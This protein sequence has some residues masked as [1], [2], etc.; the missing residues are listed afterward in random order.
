MT[1]ELNAK[2]LMTHPVTVLREVETVER[3]LHIL[4]STKHNGFPVVE[5]FD[6]ENSETFGILK[7]FI[8]RHQLFTLLKHKSFLLTNRQLTPDDFREYYPTYL[9]FKDIEI[10]ENEFNLELDLRPYMNLAPYSLSENSNLP[11][12]F[13]LFRG[14]GLRHIV[15]V[16]KKNNVVGIVTRIDVAKYRAHFGF[17]NIIVKELMVYD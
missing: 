4:R 15:I 17:K 2:H 11:R 9:Q 13:R 7:G 16:D 10:S 8:L 1:E 14:L 3:V 12:I 5:G 6:S